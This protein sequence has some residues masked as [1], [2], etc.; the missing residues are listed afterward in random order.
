MADNTAIS[1]CRLRNVRPLS[2]GERCRSVHPGP[3]YL[4]RLPFDSV[5]RFASFSVRT[6]DN[7]F[8]VRWLSY[9]DLLSLK[10]CTGLMLICMVLP[11]ICHINT[12]TMS[13]DMF[14]PT[15]Y[16]SYSGA[17][18]SRNID[19]KLTLL[20]LIVY[21]SARC[22][23]PLILYMYDIHAT[24]TT[25]NMTSVH[26]D[27][28]VCY[29]RVWCAWTMHCTRCMPHAALPRW[30]YSVSEFCSRVFLLCQ[31]HIVSTRRRLFLIVWFT[32]PL[33]IHP[34]TYNYT[35]AYSFYFKHILKFNTLCYVPLL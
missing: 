33:S 18:H 2:S 22:N 20:K 1:G 23:I 32:R 21:M 30:L 9:N 16:I 4:P 15:Q 12:N 14:K 11:C 28:T 25:L 29:H 5:L 6:F 24:M 8:S 34:K 17:V 3:S 7:Y 13:V 26:H 31:H 35:M 10:W 27:N 19:I